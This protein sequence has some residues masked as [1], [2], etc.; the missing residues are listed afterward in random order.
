MKYLRAAFW[1]IVGICLIIAGMAN[2]QPVKLRAIPNWL[3][4]LIGVQPDITLPLYAVIFAGVGFGLVVGFAWEWLRE[5]KHRRSMRQNA[6]EV[7]KLNREVKR[8]RTEKH[9][10]DD[11]VIALLE[12]ASA[13]S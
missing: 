2:T 5:H 10:E 11:E 6:R 4:E 9:A 13:K 3:A 8:L 1:G 7:T 12:G